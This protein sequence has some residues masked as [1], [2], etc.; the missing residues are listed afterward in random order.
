METSL[1]QVSLKN[2]DPPKN[3]LDLKKKK[4]RVPLVPA[5]LNFVDSSTNEDTEDDDSFFAETEE[6]FFKKPKDLSV[7]LY[8]EP[9]C[10]VFN[11]LD[12]VC[13]EDSILELFAQDGYLSA[14]MIFSLNIESI[15]DKI[16]SVHQKS[17]LFSISK[18]FK[19]YLGGV[20]FNAQGQIIGAQAAKFNLYGKMNVTEAHLESISRNSALG[21]QLSLEQI[22]DNTRSLEDKFIDILNAERV[23]NHGQG[24]EI[25]FIIAKSFPDAVNERITGDIPKV[26]GSFV[27]M[28]VYVGV[29]LGKLSCTDNKTLLSMAGL[30]SVLMALVTSYGLCSLMG[31]FIS[32]LHNFIP[33][34]LLGLGVDDMFV[35]VQAWDRLSLKKLLLNKDQIEGQLGL[36]L[37]NSGVAITVT[38]LTD[39]LAFAVGGTTVSILIN[40]INFS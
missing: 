12:D 18:D 2:S 28:F 11:S 1:S 16:N 4:F 9:Y 26:I 23:A 15:L 29:A 33:F 40:I 25:E 6:N 7:S 21:D 38:S 34:L 37:K 19:S 36:T 22:D 31:F 39:F 35:I 10:S 27:I 32:P 20:T 3:R 13:F 30:A 17:G 5:Y 24:L 8:P 14:D